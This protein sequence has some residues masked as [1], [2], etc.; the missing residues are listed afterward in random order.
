MFEVG[1][2]QSLEVLMGKVGEGLKGG[3]G[4]CRNADENVHCGPQPTLRGPPTTGAG[5]SDHGATPLPRKQ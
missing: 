4:L 2:I 1:P 3:R 5:G